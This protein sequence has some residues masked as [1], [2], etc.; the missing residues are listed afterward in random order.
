MAKKNSLETL[1]E[2]IGNLTQEMLYQANAS[3]AIAQGKTAEMQK[4]IAGLKEEIASL[5]DEIDQLK[6]EIATLESQLEHYQND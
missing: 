5:K 3:I 6:R 2:G 1:A 4:N